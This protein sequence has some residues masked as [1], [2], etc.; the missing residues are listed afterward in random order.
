MATWMTLH[1]RRI[2]HAPG[3]ISV[4]GSFRHASLETGSSAQELMTLPTGQLRQHD[5][6]RMTLIYYSIDYMSFDYV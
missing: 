1:P 3:S 5:K 4:H 6:L 2:L